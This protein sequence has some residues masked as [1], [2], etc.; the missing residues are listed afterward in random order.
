M[1]QREMA[2]LKIIH[3]TIDKVIT[4]KEAAELLGLS[5]RQVIRLKKGVL[6]KGDTFIIHKN[7]GRKPKHAFSD[8]FKNTIVDLKKSEEYKDVN[9]SYFADLL[10]E[11]GIKVSYSSIYRILREAGISSPRKHRKRKAQKGCPEK[12]YKSR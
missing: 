9:F 3:Q 12:I 8:E 11:K 4:I 6:E 5:E 2:R 7:R 10:A 1:T